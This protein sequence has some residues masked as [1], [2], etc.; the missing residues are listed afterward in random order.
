VERKRSS[1]VR[2]VQVWSRE[3]SLV[4]LDGLVEIERKVVYAL[5]SYD[6]R[7]ECFSSRIFDMDTPTD[8]LDPDDITHCTFGEL[9]GRIFLGYRSG[10]ISFLDI[11]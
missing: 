11:N 3:K 8:L 4:D 2:E 9:N 5:E 7:G 6:L 1:T 10:D